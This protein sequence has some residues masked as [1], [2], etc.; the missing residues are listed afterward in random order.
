M[1]KII[2]SVVACMMLVFIL[3]S[4]DIASIFGGSKF[5]FEEDGDAYAFTGL[6]DS[7]DAEI[8]IPETYKKKPVTSVADKALY[9]NLASSSLTSEDVVYITSVTLPDTITKIGR[10]A[11]ANTST[12]DSLNL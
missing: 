10:E 6:G 4:C 5:T 1:K 2:L 3:C 7:K 9:F 11:F 8:V 12:M